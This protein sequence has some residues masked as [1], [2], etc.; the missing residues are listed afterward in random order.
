MSSP[1][2]FRVWK[3]PALL[4]VGIPEA[5]FYRGAAL[6]RHTYFTRRAKSRSRSTSNLSRRAMLS[7]FGS[8]ARQGSS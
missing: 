1:S 6:D 5:T 3:F 7:Q 2:K 4:L 8:F